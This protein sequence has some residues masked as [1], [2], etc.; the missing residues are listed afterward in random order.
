MEIKTV[1]VVGCGT[2]GSGIAQVCAQSGCD[3]VVFEVSEEILKRGLS[4]IE[5]FLKKGME[6]D[7][8]LQEAKLSYLQGSKNLHPFYWSGFIL[9][10]NE[11]PLNNR[12][13]YYYIL[14]VILLTLIPVFLIRKQRRKKRRLTD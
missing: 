14:L 7:R 9:I 11:S 2:M 10:G 1:G 3:V 6:K 13:K 4:A 5:A 12:S 8:A